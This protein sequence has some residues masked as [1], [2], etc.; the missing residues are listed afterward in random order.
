VALRI[1]IFSSSFLREG[2]HQMSQELTDLTAEVAATR[3]V[4]Q[5]AVLLIQGLARRLLDAGTDPAK[6]QALRDDLA[7]GEADLSA[8]VAANQPPAP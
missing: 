3:G 7:L 4:M 5:S 8:A 2:N 1:R 6:L